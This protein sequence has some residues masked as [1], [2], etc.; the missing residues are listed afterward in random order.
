MKYSDIPNIEDVKLK[1]YLSKC[2]QYAS[3]KLIENIGNPLNTAYNEM[4]NI[5]RNIEKYCE[6]RNKF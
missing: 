4:R 5:L 2:I 6:K 1:E 3:D